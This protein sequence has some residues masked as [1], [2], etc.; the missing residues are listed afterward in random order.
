MPT[1]CFIS[2]FYN[3]AD[4]QKPV[5]NCERFLQETVGLDFPKEDFY[6]CQIKSKDCKSIKYSGP[7][8]LELN[9][10]S[11]LWHKERC[12]NLLIK[13][14]NLY[15]KYDYICWLDAD[16]R[17]EKTIVIPTDFDFDA[18]QPFKTSLRES[19]KLGLS[20]QKFSCFAIN[21]EGDRGL[22]W[23]IKSNI[24]KSVG[25]F[26]DYGIVGGGDYYF[27]HRMIG[28]M[29][30]IGCEH[31]DNEL[32]NYF[33]DRYIHPKKVGYLDNTVTHMFHG[34]SDNR[35]YNSRIEILRKKNFNP[36]DDLV[37]E[38]S[39]LYRLKDPNFEAEVKRYF[40]NRDEDE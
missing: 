16:I 14:F 24:L 17:F 21:S 4:F 8:Y 19:D 22:G 11:V 30:S 35:Q 37:V 29:C 13:K 23:A 34:N 7:N 32:D 6:F 10:E 12:F 1:I 20:R 40:I 3:P 18:F 38:K 31:F 39:G 36:L 28:K 15:S 27:T 5:S 2:T 9:S 25:G 26:Y 33:K